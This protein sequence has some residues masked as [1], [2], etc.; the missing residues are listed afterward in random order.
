[1]DEDDSVADSDASKG[2]EAAASQPVRKYKSIPN[3]VDARGLTDVEKETLAN[4]EKDKGN[5]VEQQPHPAIPAAALT[6]HTRERYDI[7]MAP[8]RGWG[9][10]ICD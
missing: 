3:S 6:A 4:R 9:R 5:E 2:V 10:D 1:M 8:V 7:D